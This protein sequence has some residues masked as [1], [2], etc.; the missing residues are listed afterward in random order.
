MKNEYLPSDVS[1]L[2]SAVQVG[3]LEYLEN[4][5]VAAR[6][7]AAFLQCRAALGAQALEVDAR[8]VRGDFG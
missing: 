2:S 4:G 5:S 1:R 6:R 8:R 7:L 3:I